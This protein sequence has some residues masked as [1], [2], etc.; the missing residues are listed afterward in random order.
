NNTMARFRLGVY[1]AWQCRFEEALAVL[2][3]VPSDVSPMLIERVRAEV[4]VEIGRLDNAKEIVDEYLKLYPSDEGGSF[5]G[6]KALLFAKSGQ[7]RRAKRTIDRAIAIGKGFGHFH[8][9]AYNIASAYA[10]LNDPDEAVRWLEAAADDGFPC[11]PYFANDPNLERLRAEPR[12]VALM[13]VL[14][15][16]SAR[17]KKFAEAA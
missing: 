8:H 4:L 10:A 14:Q 12:F 6:M 15:R 3:T 9:T 5:T 1:T 13:T 11:Y 17:F 16:Q 2:K 7:H